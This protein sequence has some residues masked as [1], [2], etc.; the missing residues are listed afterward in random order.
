M[1]PSFIANARLQNQQISHARFSTPAEVVAWMGAMQGQDYTGVKWSV[2]LRLPNSTN[3]DIEAALAERKIVRTWAMRGTL[4]LLAAADARWIVD[5]LAPRLIISLDRRRKQLEIDDATIARAQAII[6]TVLQGGRQS[7]R[8]DLAA[9]L[10]Q[11]GVMVNGQRAYHI[12]INL[13]L[14]GLLVQGQEHNKE[15]FFTLRE[16]AL[17]D[18]RP[19]PKDEA[20]AALAARYF[21]SHG[22]AT[23]HDFAWWSGQNVTDARAGLNAI[24]ETLMTEVVGGQTYWLA[25]APSGP[26]AQTAYALPGFDEY[27]LG[28]KVRDSVLDP[29]HADKVC[30]GQNG[31]FFPTVVIDGQMVGTWKRAVNKNKISVEITPFSTIAPAALAAFTHALDSFGKFWGMPV[32]VK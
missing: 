24:K 11:N 7:T 28:Y 12:L 31:V 8:K 26:P 9:A 17:P 5:L 10:E 2:G 19:L 4:H 14:M 29:A 23:I 15:P 6:I 22:P 18:A 3:A 27:L 13:S 30:P 1:P 21:A 20:L 16:E 32:A 25:A